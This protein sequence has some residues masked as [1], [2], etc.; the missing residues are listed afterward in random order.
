MTSIRRQLLIWLLLG[1]SV[2]TLAAAFAVYRQTRIEAA[3]LFDYQL[4]V[5]AAA[6]PN[7]GF[8]PPSTP[9]DSDA[10][11][12]DVVV[13]Q[14][15]DQNGAQVYLSRPGS[16]VLRRLRLGFS[17]VATPRGDWRVYSTLIAGNVIQVSQPM[18]ARDELAAGLALRALL[19][20]LI[21]LPA[22]LIFIWIT[23]G[24]GLA[25]LENLAGAV[26]RR[27]EDALEPLPA[28]PLPAEVKPLVAALNDL[29]RR[30]GD[31]LTLQRAFI[32]DA[33]HEL[34]TPLT[35]VKLQIQLAE[36]ASSPDERSKAFSRLKAGADRAA[37][38]VQ[39]LL[40]LA[41]N[42]AGAGERTLAAVDL[43]QI[44]RDAV[45]EEAAIAEAKGV[46]L[47]LTADGPVNTAGDPDAL[48]TLIGNLIDN[49]VRYTQAG[50]SVDVAAKMSAGRPTWVVTDSGPGIPAAER[51]RVF[52]RFYRA[53]TG[54][55]EGSGLGLSIVQRI[56][57]RHRA[58]VEL[59]GG[60]GG[61][62][63]TVTVRFPA[64]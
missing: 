20:F 51:Q 30:L 46:E 62:G 26:N 56:A 9:P 36:R 27:S 64:G 4:Q 13:V 39:Q 40:T 59:T 44:A 17:T 28:E 60:P 6:F 3:E 58:A 1:L 25:P 10:G 48:R 12:G 63:L 57:Q 47:G 18:R 5:M 55:V 14:I 45:A 34:R 33:A 29:L 43:T 21:L 53:D 42:E 2:S 41:R 23:V 16:P 8:A 50:G 24:R 7:G 19:P 52:D 22:L 37:H 15:W 32:A 11:S 38:L 49:A 31:A 35:A 54:G 61:Q